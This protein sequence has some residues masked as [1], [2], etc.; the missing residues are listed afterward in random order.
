MQSPAFEVDGQY[1]L[2]ELQMGR[3]YDGGSSADVWILGLSLYRML[4]GKYPFQANNDHRLLFTKMQHVDVGIPSHLSSDAKD[5]LRRMLAPNHSRAS[6]DLVM[7]HPWLKPYSVGLIPVDA[8]A[9]MDGGDKL[10]SIRQPTS[11]INDNNNK[12]S[13]R[14]VQDHHSRSVPT[15]SMPVFTTHHRHSSPS[16]KKK[17]KSIVS[18]LKKVIVFIAKGPCPPPTH[19]YRDLSQTKSF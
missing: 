6:L 8:L 14:G 4:V 10:D 18:K 19:P 13:P 2:P 3:K 5:L 1:I 9:P 12:I 11:T 15:P 16:G 17:R 7:F